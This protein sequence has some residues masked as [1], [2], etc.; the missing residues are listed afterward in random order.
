M[1]AIVPVVRFGSW[2]VVVGVSISLAAIA[3]GVV[4][5]RMLFDDE[6]PL[7]VWTTICLAAVAF[8]VWASVM[9]ARHQQRT[10]GD[11]EDRK[12]NDD[13]ATLRSLIGNINYPVSFLI[14]MLALTANSAIKSCSAYHWPDPDLVGQA[15]DGPASENR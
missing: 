12:T 7:W 10:S 1:T 13:A 3:L 5:E 9:G 2:Q 8:A 15:A 6:W 4:M 11:G 14:I